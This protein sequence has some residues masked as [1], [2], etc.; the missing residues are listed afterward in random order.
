MIL[1]NLA[2]LHLID[3]KLD[4]FGN[5]VLNLLPCQLL[6]NHFFHICRIVLVP[7]DF[8]DGELKVGIGH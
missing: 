4:N 1:L 7:R 8:G 5:G 3:P 2:L 6:L